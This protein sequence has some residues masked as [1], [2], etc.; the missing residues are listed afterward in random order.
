[1][2]PDSPARVA[3]S[4]SFIAPPADRP[5]SSACCTTGSPKVAAYS[6]ARRIRPD[7]MTGRPSSDTATMPA[8]RISP[9][10]ASASP[11]TPCEMA[12]T[13]R[14]RTRSTSRARRVMSS[15]TAR[16]SFGGCVFGMQQTVVKPPAAAARPPD[17]MSSL[18]SWPGSR[19]WTWR[20]TK[21]GSRSAPSSSMT[22]P[23]PR[24]PGAM[25]ATLPPSTS[26][27]ASTSVPLAGSMSRPPRSRIVSLTAATAEEVEDRHADG[28]AVGHLLEDDRALAVGDRR[29]HLDA[30]VDRPGM[31]DDGVLL[32]PGQRA[33]RQ[34]EVARV[35]ARVGE[36]ADFAQPFLLDAQHHDHVRALERLLEPAG[37]AHAG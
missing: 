9:I 33:R 23:A 31:H 4:P 1:G 27:S 30:A 8:S 11:R 3:T 10:S 16:Q 19:R 37:D 29:V 2:C 25:R 34:A 28:D 20:S 24:C 13:G 15:V 7:D 5:R 22:R 12:P 26:T 17:A 18:Y 35:L 6:S 36:Q 32:G 14:T 21:P